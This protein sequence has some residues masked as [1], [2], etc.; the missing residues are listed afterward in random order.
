MLK[1]LDPILN[2]DV[3]YALAAMGHGDEIA[4]VD[5]NFPSASVAKRLIRLDGL[6]TAPVARAIVSVFPLDTFVDEP[7][8]RMQVVEDAAQ[9]PEVQ[10]E[11]LEIAGRADGRALRMG[12]L[13]RMDF[14]ERARSAFAVVATGETRPYGCFLLSKGVVAVS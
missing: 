12:G 4:I 11:F 9:V 13:P 1:G 5:R 8:I 7:I 6:G 14:Y 2:A 3:L 10:S